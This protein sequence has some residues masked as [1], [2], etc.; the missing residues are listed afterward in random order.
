MQNLIKSNT[1][2]DSGFI[3]LN[4]MRIYIGLLIVA[5]FVFHV[6]AVS[7]VRKSIKKSKKEKST[8]VALDGSAKYTSIQKAIDEAEF[9]ATIRIKAGVY[10][11]R[12][13]MKNFVNLEGEG[14]GKT[15]LTTI[16]E[17]PVI[18][19]YNLGGGRITNLSVEFSK[20][21]DRPLIFAKFST[22]S[23]EKCSFK[24]GGDG[25]EMLNNSSV[26]IHESTFIGNRRNGISIK[27][28][29]HGYISDCSITQNG[30]DGIFISDNASPTIER[31]V[32]KNNGRN[33]ITVTANST[34]KIFGNYI[35]ENKRS[36]ISIDQNSSPLIRNNTILKN[37]ARLAAVQ[38]QIEDDETGFG[39]LVRKTT[40]VSMINNIIAWNRYGVGVRESQE[41]QL[42]KNNLWQNDSNYAGIVSHTSDMQADPVFIN[43]AEYNFKI[44]TTSQLYRKGEDGVSIGAHY[45]NTRIEKKRRL[46]YLKTQATK[47]IARENWFY[48]YQ[49]AQEI[50]SIDKDDTEGKTLFKKAA[51]EVAN[52]YAQKAKIDFDAGNLRVAEN[53]L[54]VALKYDPDNTEALELKE[55]IGEEAM[56]DRVK[57]LTVLFFGITGLFVFGYWWKKRIQN[58][59]IRRQVQ[60]WLDDSEEQIALAR[61]SDAE[62]HS[63]EDLGAALKKLSEAQQAFAAK[64][65]ETCE[66]LCNEAARHAMRARDDAEKQKQI[67]KNAHLE[68]SNAE[69]AMYS[70]SGTELAKR[71]ADAIKEFSFYLERA[72]DALIH[73]QFILAKEIAEDIQS[74]L[75]KLQDQLQ[76]EK[77]DNVRALIDK[78]EKLIIETLT[79]NNSA[80]IIVA[81]IDFKAE[82]E[83][84]KNGFLSERLKAE[85]V[86]PQIEQIKEFITEALRLGN[87]DDSSFRTSRKKN[88]YEILGV[89]EGA[90][91]EQIKSV[92]RKLS[93]IYHPDMDNSGDLGI[94]GDERFKEIKEAYEALISHQTNQKV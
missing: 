9:N 45:D 7:Q 28:K 36:G 4:A 55:L 42:S 30:L 37:G 65:Y 27:E 32:I 57:T 52:S 83:I 72:Q 74:S 11:E 29:S 94:A 12:I 67:R 22:F 40:S 54:N 26:N 31:N 79:S 2:A 50:L 66:M 92:Y 87:Q 49:S 61:A 39:I 88:Y 62:K 16:G 82:L 3:Q 20:S 75:K 91:L 33:G 47:D 63:P 59:E 46:D 13:L 23:I 56:M 85:E 77:G 24:N 60:W 71:F 84:L 68:V 14:I 38:P 34:N 80:D 21:S 15:V 81:V 43:A 89:K 69:A 8:L 73:K 90:T 53:Y 70:A 17:T 10:N 51:T 78:T 25:I 5:F 93:M 6:A 41:I 58:G 86:I 64:Q 19:A 76:N 48:A 18:E 44:D 35:F 1:L